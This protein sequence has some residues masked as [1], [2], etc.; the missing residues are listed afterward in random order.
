MAK[1]AYD[2]LVEK[3]G[4]PKLESEG[5]CVWDIQGTKVIAIKGASQKPKGAKSMDDLKAAYAASDND[6]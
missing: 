4:P 6:E 2:E 5:V 1:K 3:L